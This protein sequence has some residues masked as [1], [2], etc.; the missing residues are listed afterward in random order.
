MT[1]PVDEKLKRTRR[2][3]RLRYEFKA[4]LAG[5]VAAKEGEK[6]KPLSRA[7]RVLVDQCALLSLRAQQMRDDILS[8]ER[9]VSDENLV[10]ATNAAIRAMKALEQRKAQQT[11]ADDDW[12]A[13][14]Y[15]MGRKKDETD[16]EETDA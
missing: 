15:S 5:K 6:T 3:R 2:F 10:R 4:E 14:L 1:T 11:A 7:D 8:G 13:G 16:D 9:E 12:Q